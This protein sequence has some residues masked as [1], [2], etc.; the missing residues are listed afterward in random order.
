MHV[1]EGGRRGHDRDRMQRRD[2]RDFDRW[3]LKPIPPK[4]LNLNVPMSDAFKKVIASPTDSGDPAVHIILLHVMASLIRPST[5]FVARPKRDTGGQSPGMTNG[6]G[7]GAWLSDPAS[8]NYG[9]YE[10]Q[11]ELGHLLPDSA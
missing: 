7:L 8:D 11:L 5:T 1:Q 2:Q 9:A 4:G 3:F 10:L 6:E